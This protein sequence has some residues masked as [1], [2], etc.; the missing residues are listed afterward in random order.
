MHKEMSERKWYE[1]W[2]RN[3]SDPLMRTFLDKYKLHL[4]PL[5]LQ[6]T[7]VG[8][9]CVYREED[10][11]GRDS[12]TLF[13]EQDYQISPVTSGK[14][15]DIEGKFSQAISVD[16]G[17][18]LLENFLGAFGIGNIVQKIHLDFQ[19]KNVQYLKF[20]FNDTM[21]NAVSVI[22]LPKIL[23]K[24]LLLLMKTILYFLKQ[25]DTIS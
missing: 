1:F 15:G 5:P 23:L 10:L 3:T 12:I 19:T 25:I 24:K 22:R 18:G 11:I 21:R 17:L 14:M 16:I 20:A 8:Q 6:D 13:L 4:L 7:L 9:I 2:K